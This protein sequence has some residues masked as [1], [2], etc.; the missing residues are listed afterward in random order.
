MAKRGTKKN[1]HNQTIVISKPKVK[2]YTKARAINQD[3]K[4]TPINSNRQIN[5]ARAERRKQILTQFGIGLF[6]VIFVVAWLFNLKYEFKANAT[7]N[8][9][10]KFDWNQTKAE[11]DKA[12]AQVKQGLE[13]IKKINQLKMQNTL[14]G[15]PKLTKEQIDLL[16][17]KIMNEVATNTAS[18]TTE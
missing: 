6:M 4:D 13:E 8:N 12:M 15:E 11:L 7:R 5:A 1:N 9:Q 18:S 2:I 10:N 17:N 14:P 16:K 3:K